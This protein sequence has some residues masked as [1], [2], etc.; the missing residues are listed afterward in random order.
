MHNSRRRGRLECF[1]LRRG[2]EQRRKLQA[3]ASEVGA[4]AGTSGEPACPE[5][6][7]THVE[8]RLRLRVNAF[9]GQVPLLLLDVGVP[10]HQI[11]LCGYRRERRQVEDP[12]RDLRRVEVWRLIAASDSAT[13]EI[14]RA[15][16]SPARVVDPLVTSAVRKTAIVRS[17][18]EHTRT[19]HT[20]RK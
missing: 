15:L 14:L 19:P 4:S 18:R 8:E 13:C 9:A 16:S 6:S 17:G 10:A 2:S 3:P 7:V 20:F 11:G 5:H 1:G 12:P